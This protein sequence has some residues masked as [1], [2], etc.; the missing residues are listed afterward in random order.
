MLLEPGAVGCSKS[1]GAEIETGNL[2]VTMTSDPPVVAK[3]AVLPC[4]IGSYCNY[5][6]QHLKEYCL[7]SGTITP[8]MATCCGAE[9]GVLALPHSPH[10]LALGFLLEPLEV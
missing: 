9:Q 8:T 3:T 5:G 2:V 1:L 4:A 6:P 7:R 10:F